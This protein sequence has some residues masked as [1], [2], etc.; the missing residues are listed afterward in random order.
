MKTTSKNDDKN[1]PKMEAK[2]TP[3]RAKTPTIRR[4]NPD[5]EPGTPPDAK[6]E[7][8]AAKMEP[9]MRKNRS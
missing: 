9:K 7:G 6:K 8:K 4:Q 1:A 2:G 3:N 5:M